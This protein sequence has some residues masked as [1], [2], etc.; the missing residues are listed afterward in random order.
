MLGLSGCHAGDRTSETREWLCSKWG[1]L[2]L[3]GLKMAVFSLSMDW[4]KSVKALVVSAF[5]VSFEEESS[6]TVAAEVDGA[7]ADGATSTL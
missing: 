2:P 3:W 4:K 5:G 1:H 7:C 6:G